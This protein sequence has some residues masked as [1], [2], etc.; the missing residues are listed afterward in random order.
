MRT[1]VTAAAFATIT[2][3]IV[4]ITL[5]AADATLAIFATDAQVTEP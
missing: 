1:I 5:R 2:P 3:F 4:A